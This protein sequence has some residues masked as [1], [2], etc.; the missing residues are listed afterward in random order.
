MA[1]NEREANDVYHCTGRWGNSP[2][3]GDIV[4]ISIL[5]S[6][7]LPLSAAVNS[8]IKGVGCGVGESDAGSLAGAQN[9]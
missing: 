8:K 9:R 1:L 4:P 7:H 6:V 5:G 3:Q 2:W